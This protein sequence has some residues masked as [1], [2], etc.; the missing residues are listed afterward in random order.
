MSGYDPA[1]GVYE[2]T[3]DQAREW[4]HDGYDRIVKVLAKQGLEVIFVGESYVLVRATPAAIW[5]AL[6]G[7]P[8]TRPEHNQLIG[9]RRYFA[10][11]LGHLVRPPM[12][13]NELNMLLDA[14]GLIYHDGAREWEL[15]ATGQRYGEYVLVPGKGYDRGDMVRS[16]HWDLAVLDVLG[17]HWP[18]PDTT[19]RQS[20]YDLA[21]FLAAQNPQYS[22]VLNELRTGR[23]TSHWMWYIFPQIQGLGSSDTTRFYALA[24]LDEAKAYLAHAVLGPRLR[25]CTGLVNDVS[26]SSIVQMFGSVDAM[27]FR[28]SMT[29]FREATGDNEAFRFALT[30]YFDGKPDE[31]TLAILG[32]A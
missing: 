24:S 15:T 32:K 13:A 28:S 6:T 2:L 21:R 16:V 18:K 12:S 29:L 1:T 27:K 3:A 30:K 11:Y 7:K 25:E 20:P 8:S 14:A 10:R 31:R 19:T 23:K 22:Q 5:T 17:L 26:N 4:F 9:R